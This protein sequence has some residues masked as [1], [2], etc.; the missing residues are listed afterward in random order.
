MS[1]TN[2]EQ[3]LKWAYWSV[4][5]ILAFTLLFTRTIVEY[6]GMENTLQSVVILVAP[7]MIA[8][9]GIEWMTRHRAK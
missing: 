8:A 1:K 7:L 4:L 2:V 5:V 3:L 9:V 6:L